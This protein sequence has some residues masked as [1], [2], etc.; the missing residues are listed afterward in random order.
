MKWSIELVNSYWK[1]G[2][3][4]T[5][6]AAT[7]REG[8]LVERYGDE[9]ED[10]IVFAVHN[11]SGMQNYFDLK[12]SAARLGIPSDGYEVTD[13]VSGKR[14]PAERSNGTLVIHGDLPGHKRAL[15]VIRGKA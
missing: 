5:T 4:P 1:L 11:N 6:L 15:Y 13:L 2:W 9:L 10:G 12:V 7:N 8:V 3:Q 14:V